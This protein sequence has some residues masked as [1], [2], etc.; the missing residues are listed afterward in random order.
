MKAVIPAAGLGMRLLPATKEIPKEML[1]LFSEGV[2]KPLL[3]VI[4]EEL[5]R[6]GVREF[7][8]I[9]GRTKRA[10]EDHF[11]ADLEIP[12]LEEFYRILRDSSLMW[13]NQPKPKGLG[14]AVMMAKPFTGSE[15][16]LVHAGDTYLHPHEADVIE[17][18]IETSRE[19]A[20]AVFLMTEVKDPKRYGVPNL[21]GEKNGVYEVI[22]VEEKPEEPKSNMAIV[23]IYVFRPVIHEALAQIGV[24]KGEEIQL[25][26]AIQKL[27]EWKRPV[28]AVKLEKGQYLDIGKAENYLKALMRSAG[29]INV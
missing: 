10:I 24:G 5:Y 2:L 26:D 1:P 7:C 14:D 18:L 15:P 9:T 4:Y 3:Q 20:D 23:P 21:T 8:I 11:T 27:I 29:E 6:A 13:V 19:I 12:Q 25:T 28:Y 16:F 17:G 22:G